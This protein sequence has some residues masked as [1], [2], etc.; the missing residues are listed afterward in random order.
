MFVTALEDFD[1]RPHYVDGHI[2]PDNVVTQSTLL[3]RPD[4]KHE[5]V[6][7]PSGF[8]NDL[9]SLPWFSR[10]FLSKLGKHQRCAV[11]HDWLYRNR[12][13]G[14]MWADKQFNLAMKQDNV[15]AWRR[16]T[17]MIGL[18]AGGFISWY[19]DSK[20]EVLVA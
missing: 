8:V 16:R 1:Y 17:I 10:T 6:I 3:W 14:K 7:V 13:H 20:V 9:A 15:P 2:V 4:D 19:R 5:D 11:L 12:I 18:K